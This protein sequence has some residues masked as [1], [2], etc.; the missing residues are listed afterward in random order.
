MDSNRLIAHRC[1]QG[2]VNYLDVFVVCKCRKKFLLSC[3]EVLE[4]YSKHCSCGLYSYGKVENIIILAIGIVIVGVSV[5]SIHMV[6]SCTY[7]SAFNNIYFSENELK[8]K[9]YPLSSSKL[10]GNHHNM[11][12]LYSTSWIVK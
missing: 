3:Q 8:L 9:S 4:W 1:L 7:L 2:S 11:L 6:F 5:S 10:Y 12:N